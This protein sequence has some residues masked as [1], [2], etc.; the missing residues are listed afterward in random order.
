MDNPSMKLNEL[1]DQY[2]NIEDDREKVKQQRNVILCIDQALREV[3][4]SGYIVDSFDPR[5]ITIYP[6]KVVFEVMSQMNG[7]DELMI[8]KNIM[9][10]ALL[11]IRIYLNYFD[12][13]E[14]M[15]NA[16]DKLFSRSE[17]LLGESA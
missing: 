4:D 8:K 6:P 14:E 3:H 1:L 17:E 16:V 9:D 7:N 2:Q 5:D 12:D 11:S 13:M 15:H 10:S